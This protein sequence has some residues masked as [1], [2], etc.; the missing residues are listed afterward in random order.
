MKLPSDYTVSTVSYYDTHA[1]KFCEN[2]APVDMSE[3]YAPFV[4]IQI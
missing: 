2:T 1:A 3:L 4:L